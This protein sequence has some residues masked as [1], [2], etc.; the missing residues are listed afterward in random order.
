LFAYRI[1]IN[2][3]AFNRACSFLSLGIS[4]C[5]HDDFIS[6]IQKYP[7]YNNEDL[8]IIN[9]LETLMQE[10]IS[11]AISSSNASLS[12]YGILPK[13]ELKLEFDTTLI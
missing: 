10:S 6:V 4:L 8:A 12:S 13:E 2:D 3:Y 5:V 9:K 1:F 7:D 11:E